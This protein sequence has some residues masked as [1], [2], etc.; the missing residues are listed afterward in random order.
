MQL[1]EIQKKIHEIREQK[2]MLDFD[3]A[4]LY[5]TETKN[6]NKAVKETFHGFLKTLCFNLLKRNG[7]I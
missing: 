1:Q 3:I 6:L 5:E 7:N 4:E 2:V